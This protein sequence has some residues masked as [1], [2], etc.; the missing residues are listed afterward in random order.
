[1]GQAVGTD[2]WSSGVLAITMPSYNR[3]RKSARK[4]RNHNELVELAESLGMS[5]LEVHQLPGALDL[6]VGCYGIDRRIEIKDGAKTASERK[7]SQREHEEFEKWRGHYPDIWETEDDVH[8]TR[9][10][11]LAEAV[12]LQ[13][14]WVD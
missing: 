12:L 13:K 6:V 2:L 5:V 3:P 11:M 7:L 4:D 10:S 9:R 1:M 8:E 14:Q